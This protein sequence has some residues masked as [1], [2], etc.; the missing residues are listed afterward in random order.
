MVARQFEHITT[1][2]FDLDDTLYP[3]STGFR[4][5]VALRI[6]E[7]VARDNGLNHEE[8]LSAYKQRLPENDNHAYRTLHAL[9]TERGY[10]W[11]RD[12]WQAEFQDMDYSFM[13]AC[14]ETKA[15]LERLPGRKVIFTN[16]CQV[17][18][19]KMLRQLDIHEL[20]DHVSHA[21]IR[22]QRYKPEPSIYEEL[23]AELG[24]SPTEA[25]FFDDMPENLKPAHELG[26]TTVLI[27][28]DAHHEAHVHHAYDSVLDFLK[29]YHGERVAA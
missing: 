22:D 25:V 16:A 10:T 29:A 9:R 24:V 8:L 15:S 27:D 19:P 2:I 5:R 7:F 3:A 28:S 4:D 12:R 26:L 23:V 14:Y 18:T 6:L 11:D 21:D 17:H 20:F 13:E 1:W